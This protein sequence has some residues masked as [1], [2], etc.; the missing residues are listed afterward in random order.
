L[1]KRNPTFSA[2]K[3]A[4]GE[5]GATPPMPS[6]DIAVVTFPSLIVAHRTVP[7][8]KVYEFTKQLFT[9]RAGLFGQQQAA[10]RIEALPTERDSTF[11]VHP[12]AATYFD[13]TE[14]SFIETYSDVMWL[15]L[16]GFSGVVS[17]A[18]WILSLAFPRRRE[19]IQSEHAELV[20]LM[21][22]ARAAQTAADIDGIE[23]RVDQLVAQTSQLIF[24]GSID[25]DRQ[26]AFDVLITRIGQILERR[27]SELNSR[28]TQPSAV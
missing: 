4:V 22:A 6:E 14:T 7:D 13:A 19:L 16:F 11:A 8:A 27:R 9:L 26:P 2:D 18:A 17:M 20:A 24:S 15:A 28:L 25:S 23:K 5:I 12:G 1:I 10:A 3:V 21:D